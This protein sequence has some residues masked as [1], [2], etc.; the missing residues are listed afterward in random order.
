MF[1][2]FYRLEYKLSQVNDVKDD[3]KDLKYRNEQRKQRNRFLT[4]EQD[5]Q[6]KIVLD[7]VHNMES[8]EES[9]QKIPYEDVEKALNLKQ[10]SISVEENLIEGDYTVLYDFVFIII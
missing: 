10:R 3:V 2:V 4:Q 8:V 6:V 5:R 7:Q 9:K 1:L